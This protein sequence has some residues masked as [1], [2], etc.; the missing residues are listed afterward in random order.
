L[1]TAMRENELP[2]DRIDSHVK[3]WLVLKG[4][5]WRHRHCEISKCALLT[6]QT[7]MQ[8][9]WHD[10]LAT[11]HSCQ[12]VTSSVTPSYCINMYLSDSYSTGCQ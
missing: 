10:M 8:C 5:T 4:H 3:F 2:E 11:L 1:A 12:I 6:Y 7:C 9:K